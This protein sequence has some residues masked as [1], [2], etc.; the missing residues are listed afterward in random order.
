MLRDARLHGGAS[1]WAPLESNGLATHQVRSP[2]SEPKL[3]AAKLTDE[4]QPVK[5]R[6]QVSVHLLCHERT[7]T[8]CAA[9]APLLLPLN[10]VR[11]ENL[12]AGGALDSFLDHS[13]ADDADKRVDKLLL[14]GDCVFAR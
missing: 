9:Q 8:V 5:H 12:L 14:W 10:A 4:A 3:L 6:C 7:L 2:L 13:V 11:I 1:E